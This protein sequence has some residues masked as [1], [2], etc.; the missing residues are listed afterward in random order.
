V[1][2]QSP[3]TINLADLACLQYGIRLKSME[4]HLAGWK[5]LYLYEEEK[6]TLIKVCF[7]LSSLPTYFIYISFDI[8]THVANGQ[9]S[10]SRIF[11]ARE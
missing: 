11:L 6:L 3:K 2:N 7:L 10:Y 1:L 9:R 8:P 5:K 4:R